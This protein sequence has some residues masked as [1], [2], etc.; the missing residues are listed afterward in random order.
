MKT[1][2]R[3][4]M[5]AMV[6]SLLLAGNVM[7]DYTTINTPSDDWK[8]YTEP[9]MNINL[10]EPGGI[11]DRLYGLNNLVR[12]DDNADQTFGSVN[13]A[14][15]VAK[16]AN[17]GHEFGYSGDIINP[18]FTLPKND[19]A[20]GDLSNNFEQ[21]GTFTSINSIGSSFSFWLDPSPP[22][23]TDNL[24][25]TDAPIW[26]SVPSLTVDQNVDQKDHMV[27]YRIISSDATHNN[28]I[29]HYVL[30]WEDNWDGNPLKNSDWDYN[31]VVV[32]VGTPEPATMILLGFG[33]IGMV[34]LRKKFSK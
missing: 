30:A 23:G 15:V 6:A 18:I 31:D 14:R 3:I 17:Y 8:W 5:A 10:A 29:G 13:E 27:T 11:L 28:N 33:L 32:E 16:Y 19:Y 2:G 25:T 1:L 22:A 7:A 20:G 9:L 34:A 4:L 21:L 26:S 24:N 12:V